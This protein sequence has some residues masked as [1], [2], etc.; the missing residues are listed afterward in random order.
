[1]CPLSNLKLCV[2]HDLKLH[3]MKRMLDLGLKATCNSD[4][5]AYF[6]GYIADNFIRTAQ[7]VSLTCDDIVALAKNSFAGSFLDGASIDRHLA[8]IDAYAATH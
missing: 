6:G 2:V 8:A 5:P 3:P 7:A 1:V 4:D